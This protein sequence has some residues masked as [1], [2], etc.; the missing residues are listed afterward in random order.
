MTEETGKKS[1]KPLRLSEINFNLV[2]QAGVKH[3]AM[4]ALLCW[5]KKEMD[6]H[7]LYDDRPVLAMTEELPDG[8]VPLHNIRSPGT[9]MYQC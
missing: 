8:L 6:R 9:R 7:Q 1:K 5:Y 3:L 4:D 2:H